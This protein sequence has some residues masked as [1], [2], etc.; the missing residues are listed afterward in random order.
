MAASS[1][2]LLLGRVGDGVRGDGIIPL[3]LVFKESPARKIQ[4]EKCE[5]TGGPVPHTHVLP[6]PWNLLDGDV[7]SIRMSR[8]FASYVSQ[9]VMPEWVPYIQ[10][11]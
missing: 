10:K 6:T 3:D 7:P 9:G 2:L 8:D 4:I 5:Q 1:Y 11:E